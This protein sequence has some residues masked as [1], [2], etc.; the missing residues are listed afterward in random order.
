MEIVALELIKELQQSDTR[1]EYVLF[2]KEDVDD[3][4]V[5]ETSNW[6]IKKLKGKTYFDWEQFSLPAAVKKEKIDFLHSTCNTSAIRNTVPLLLTLHDIYYLEH[7]NFKGTAYQNFGNLYRRIIVP[8]VVKRSKFIITVSEYEKEVISDFLHLPKEKIKVVYNAV[9]SRFNTSY[10]VSDVENVR[11][12]Y[13]LPESYILH[14]GNTAPQKN[15]RNAII[16]YTQYC[17]STG[18]P[19]PIVILDYAKA[20]VLTQLKETKN[21]DLAKHF[22]FPGFITSNEM[23]LVYNAATLFLYP[24]LRESFGLPILEAMGCGTP[25]ITS[26]AAAMPEVAG[27]AALL[28]NPHDTDSLA[29]KIEELL[30]D[31]SLQSELTQKGIQ[32]AAQFTWKKSASDLL[33]IY[34][35]M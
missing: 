1:N 22:Y 34:K 5:S 16:A 33:E 6:K 29:E 27:N 20:L 25:V 3:T 13:Q 23:P 26:S 15:T 11:K 24:S 35:A 9:N 32:R 17:R 18:N 10:S 28:V 30:G 7:F 4:C 31:T 8:K 14:L 2:V 12:K 21:D 19:V